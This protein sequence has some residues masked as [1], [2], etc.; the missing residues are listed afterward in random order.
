M[1]FLDKLGWPVAYIKGRWI[2]KWVRRLIHTRKIK[3][4]YWNGYKVV[5][6]KNDDGSKEL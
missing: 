1:V 4:G 2:L 5:K 3:R 6:E